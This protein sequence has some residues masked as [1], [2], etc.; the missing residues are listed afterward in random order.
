MERHEI[1]NGDSRLHVVGQ[2][3]GS[4]VVILHGLAGS[5]TEFAPTANELRDHRVL[6]IDARGHGRSSTH[7]ADVSRAAHVSD[8]VLVIER[9]VGG[10]VG[11]IGQSMG[12]HT[13]MLVAAERPDLVERLVLLE[14]GVGGD[15]DDSSRAAM[16]E[17]FH[18]WPRPFGTEDDA[19]HFL[20]TGALARAWMADLEPRRDGLWARFDPDVMVATIAH[21][22][23]V[24]RWDAWVRV[25]APTLAV[26]A[27]DG[28]F[29][30]AAKT[31]LVDRG[32]D[33]RRAE[34]GGSHDAHLDAFDDWM[35]VVT[36]FLRTP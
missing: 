18:S 25:V 36:P 19:K 16:A 12:G 35:R 14:A 8:V 9:L 4:P 22:D 30:E 2:G 3:G 26:F 20:G 31:E 28:M 21:V 23:A 15:G 24:A 1:V 17:F 5:S 13:A 34:V 33:V 6:R 10:P 29:D 11:L 27:A 32:H 7:P